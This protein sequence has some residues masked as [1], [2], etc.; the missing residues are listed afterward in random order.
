[1][2]KAIHTGTG[3]LAVHVLGGIAY[4]PVDDLLQHPQ[5][6]FLL[7]NPPPFLHITVSNELNQI[8]KPPTRGPIGE[9][10]ESGN[11][12]SASKGIPQGHRK[13]IV[14]EE[15]LPSDTSTSKDSSRQK[16]HVGNR[17][18][19]SHGHEGANGEPDGNSLAPD[20]LGGS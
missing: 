6:L 12:E 9:G 19:K 4:P 7:F 18:L 16:K 8:A 10:I 20:V 5:I 2:C 13:K 3:T 15:R 1:M 14:Q 17:V 11:Q